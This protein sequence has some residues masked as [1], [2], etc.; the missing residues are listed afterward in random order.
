MNCEKPNEEKTDSDTLE[1]I[2]YLIREN[3]MPFYEEKGINAQ[4][5][6]IGLMLLLFHK[7]GG[8]VTYVRE[9]I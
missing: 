8:E 1:L 6:K 4:F 9:S 7:M 2:K 5:V 3:R